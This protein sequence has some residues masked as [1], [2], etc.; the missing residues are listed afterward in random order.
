MRKAFIGL[1]VLF[2]MACASTEPVETGDSSPT[3]PPPEPTQTEE[4]SPPTSTPQEGDEPAAEDNRSGRV[5]SATRGWETDWSQTTIDLSDLLHGG[6]PRDGIPSIDDPAYESLTEAEE[7][8]APTE[9]VISVEM[10]GEARAYPLS[11]LTRHEIVNDQL[12][13]ENIAVTFCPLCNSAL[14]FD[15]TVDGQEYEFGVSGLL[16]NSDL[17]MYDRTTESLW[18]QFTGEGIVGEHAGEQLTIIPSGLVGFEDFAEAHP[19]GDV[20]S[21]ETGIYP[22]ASYGRNPYTNYDSLSNTDPFLFSGEVDPRQ[23]AVMR[24]VGVVFDGEAV[25]YPYDA[26]SQQSVIND[27]VGGQPLVVFHQFG[28]NSALG[29][30]TIAEAEDVGG[31]GVFD[32]TVD[33]EV[34]TFTVEGEQIVD[35]QTGS[36]WNLLGQATGGELE[37][38]QL[39]RLTST[40]HFWFSWAAFYPETNVWSAQ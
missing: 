14:V 34:L 8:L 26:L 15:S 36:T 10:N 21:R 4:P 38:T 13:G 2:L 6:P 25:A 3:A 29:A 16:R 23:P 7:W 30:A 18:Q 31:T 11:I 20:L 39:T 27:E 37:G 40:D 5:R 9:P 28:V 35:E 32:R 1:V 17:V 19:E 22:A 12:G 33:G 24:V